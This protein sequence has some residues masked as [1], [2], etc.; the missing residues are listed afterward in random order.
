MKSQTE[1]LSKLQQLELELAKKDQGTLDDYMHSQALTSDQSEMTKGYLIKVLLAIFSISLGTTGSY[2]GFSPPAAILTVINTDIAVMLTHTANWRW[3]YYVYIILI[4]CAFVLEFLFYHPPT[5][6]QL[7]GGQRTL[8]EEFSRIDFIGVFLFVSGLALFLLG[9]SW[10]GQPLPWKS[11]R[12]LC[13][14]IIGGII[15]ILFILWEI[16][17]NVSN[18][19]VPMHFFKDVR[20]FVCLNIICIVSGVLYVSLS[21]IWP[22]QV[23]AI[24]GAQAK[25]WRDNAWLSTTIAFGIWGGI[26]IFGSLFHVV[27]HIR[28]QVIV[29][30]LVST[31]FA[32]ALASGNTHN[33]GQSAAFS[34]LATFPAG[35]LELIPVTL[36]QLDAN[37][38]DLGSVFAI[39]FMMRTAWGSIFT[40]V[41]LAILTNKT[42]SEI[43]NRVP[44]AAIAAGLPS[45]SLTSLFAA[46]KV[47]T[48][49][50]LA[51]V[52][53]INPTIQQAVASSLAD[54]YA[55]SYAY[56][57]YAAVAVGGV[58]LI[59]AA[60][61]KDYDHMLTSHVSRRIY[62]NQNIGDVETEAQSNSAQLD[63]KPLSAHVER[64]II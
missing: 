49:A 22:S 45:S 9:V 21:V 13:L 46:I 39:I 1:E 59:A 6:N 20:G 58:G 26:V 23:A 12:I 64:E 17:S 18:P 50:A 43:A 7:H 63:D 47:G 42:P 32:G 38:A 34:F 24:Y 16:Y 53:G 29:F 19:L 30:T 60:S 56:V 54:A 10:G 48:P 62:T 25:G 2:W 61:M 51:A 28:L 52:P 8:A 14:I 37:D 35:I 4:G 3:C 31:A 11:V 33:K 5:F 15:L 55:A 44:D 41:F 57:Y 36:C 27:K 40:T